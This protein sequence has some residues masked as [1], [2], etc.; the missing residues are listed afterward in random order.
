MSNLVSPGHMRT[1]STRSG[2]ARRSNK[3][4]PKR[5]ARRARA[6]QRLADHRYDPLTCR[7]KSKV[8]PKGL[9][10]PEPEA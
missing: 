1:T 4:H 7:H 3:G 8:C 10:N 5:A 2:P 6:A 9:W